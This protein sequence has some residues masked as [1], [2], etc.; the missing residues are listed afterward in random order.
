ME[1]LLLVFSIPLLLILHRLFQDVGKKRRLGFN[2]WSQIKTAAVSSLC[3]FLQILLNL[4][5][6]SFFFFKSCSW[7][8]VNKSSQIVK[9]K[10]RL[11][12]EVFSE[13]SLFKRL[14]I[15][16]IPIFTKSHV[17]GTRIIVRIIQLFRYKSFKQNSNASF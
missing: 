11:F 1:L 17:N 12:F 13:F 6:P 14:E 5:I 3:S 15:Q 8:S 2:F 10:R 9:I 7:S 4:S 16:R